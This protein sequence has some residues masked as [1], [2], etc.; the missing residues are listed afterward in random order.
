MDISQLFSGATS[1]QIQID[2]STRQVSLDSYLQTKPLVYGLEKNLVKHNFILQKDAPSVCAQRLQQGEVELGLIPSIEYANG[3]GAW[4]VVPG[5]CIASRGA[6][7]SVALFFSNDL[8][9]IR[10]IALDISSRS[11]VALLKILMQEKYEIDPDYLVMPPELNEMLQRADAAL[12]IGDRALN[13]QKQN[14]HYLDL[15]EE[16]FDM[17]GL[18]FVYA[19]WAGH[20]LALKAADVLAIQESYRLGAEN[21]EEISRAFAA[22][23]SNGWEF[24][25]DYLT[26]NISYRFG[27]QEKEG[28]SEFYRYAFYFGLIDHIPDLH[29]F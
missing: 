19:F 14:S 5:L 18:P 7:K 4:K 29:F 10:T 21:I 28:L 11:S 13:Y 24:Y 16:W 2:T 27:E 22:V 1:P 25:R 6:A 23:Q 20:E 26:K 8:S 3:K 17:T 9:K 15:G 12:I